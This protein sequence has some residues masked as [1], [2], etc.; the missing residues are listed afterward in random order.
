M[1]YYPEYD[2]FY[3]H[4]GAA[5][6]MSAS[7]SAI[8][9]GSED[10][11]VGGYAGTTYLYKSS[12]ADDDGAAIVSYLETKREGSARVVRDGAQIMLATDN[13]VSGN[14]SYEWYANNAKTTTGAKS[15][16]I[17]STQTDTLFNLNQQH[18]R[19]KHRIADSIT[20]GRTRIEQ[21]V[22]SGLITGKL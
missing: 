2:A 6:Q 12:G 14:L 11:Y 9:S 1:D 4:D 10:V 18:T 17:T 20:T 21:L 15:F 22:H 5:A 19:I 16:A 7:G 3:L 13:P 8:V